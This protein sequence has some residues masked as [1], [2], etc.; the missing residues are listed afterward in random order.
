MTDTRKALGRHSLVVDLIAEAPGLDLTR[1]YALSCRTQE[2]FYFHVPSAAPP[3]RLHAPEVS[4]DRVVVRVTDKPTDM[5]FRLCIRTGVYISSWQISGICLY[6]EVSAEYY[7]LLCAMMG[8]IQWRTLA[9][10][11]IL[12]MEDLVHDPGISCL[13]CA[14][15]SKAD[16]VLHLERPSLCLSCEE[17]YQSLGLES[18]V[19]ALQ[20]VIRH[21]YSEIGRK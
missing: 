2:A 11:S 1:L 16:F 8:A 9:L 15:K 19:Y 20:N 10:N 4:A 21:K 17:F 5:P 6:T 13:F 7:L 12:R 14:A 18:E 3:R